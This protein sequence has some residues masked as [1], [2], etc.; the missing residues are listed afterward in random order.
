M[1]IQG[2]VRGNLGFEGGYDVVE[3]ISDVFLVHRVL[4]LRDASMYTDSFEVGM[5]H[6]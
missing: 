4:P 1:R 2:S 6:T 5:A 3:E